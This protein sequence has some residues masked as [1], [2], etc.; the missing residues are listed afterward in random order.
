MASLP[1]NAQDNA[2]NAEDQEF[3]PMP[4]GVYHARLMEVDTSRSGAKGPY[5]VFQYDILD[6]GYTNRKM[7]D[8]VSLSDGAAFKRKQV[9]TALGFDLD[10]DTE[11]MLGS[12]VK[13]RI[14]HRTIQGGAREGELGE[15]VSKVEPADADFAQAAA[16]E[17]PTKSAAT[18]DD[19]F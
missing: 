2:A 19:V 4:V 1:K 10:T 12:V 8:N 9:W 5:W 15:Q 6:E 16:L 11:D 18:A 13:L 3:A 7:W 14:T 17:Q